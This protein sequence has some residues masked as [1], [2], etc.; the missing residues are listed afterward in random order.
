MFESFSYWITFGTM[1]LIFLTFQDLVHRRVV[2]DRH[3]Y[4]MMGM[5]FSLLWQNTN[6]WWYLITLIVVISLLAAFISKQRLMGSADAKSIVWT[7]I[8][9]GILST[10]S[11][12]FYAISL[13]L[14]LAL[15]YFI[16]WTL[17]KKIENYDE[18]HFPAYPAFLASFIL[19]S[20]GFN[21]F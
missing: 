7:F 11:L 18:R 14:F 8:G 13:L 19:T 1:Y 4:F 12:A 5:T 17:R 2:D 3:N 10:H 16:H 20:I 6:A 21:L 9:F 15:I